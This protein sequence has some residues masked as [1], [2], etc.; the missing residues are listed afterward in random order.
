MTN[1]KTLRTR[2]ERLEA[3]RQDAPV[4]PYYVLDGTQNAETLAR[5][6]RDIEAYERLC[7]D[8]LPAYVIHLPS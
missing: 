2:I 1:I 6:R 8:G 5:I 7:P 4:P 3:V